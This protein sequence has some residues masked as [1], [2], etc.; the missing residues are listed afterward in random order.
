[1]VSRREWVPCFNYGDI[2]SLPAVSTGQLTVWNE[3]NLFVAN[4]A[5]ECTFLR[6][7]GHLVIEASSPGAEGVIGWRV[8]VGLTDLAVG[9]A[10]ATAGELD[11]IDVAEEHFLDERFWWFDTTAQPS[12]GDHP[13][14]YTFDTS[15][16]RKLALPQ[17]LVISFLNETSEDLRV[18]PFIR[19][20]FL[21]A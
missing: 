21:F 6:L 17:A 18:T 16:K 3:D 5:D 7:K 1:M 10:A 15:S 4:A 11:Q 13:Y 14:Y 19:G 2:A 12:A 20:L 8:R 9:G